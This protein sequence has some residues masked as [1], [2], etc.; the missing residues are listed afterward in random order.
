MIIRKFKDKDIEQM[1]AIWNE[2]VEE[3]IAFPQEEILNETTGR[4]QGITV[5]CCC[6]EQRPCKALV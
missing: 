5:Q 6:R 3:G 1:V 4:V 2:I